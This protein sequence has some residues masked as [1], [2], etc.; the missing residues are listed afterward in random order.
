MATGGRYRVR[1]M[2]RHAF[3]NVR[4]GAALALAGALLSGC[5]LDPEVPS[6]EIA[7]PSHFLRA[8][9]NGR[10]PGDFSMFRSRTLTGL[11]E[12]AR[13]GNLDIGAA[14]ARIEQADAQVRISTQA[15]IPSL[16]ISGTSAKQM[17]SQNGRQSI[18]TPFNAQFSASYVLDFWGQNRAARY[19]AEAG[20]FQSRFD[21]ATVAIA[22]DASVANAYFQAAAARKR[23]TVSKAD[24]GAAQKDLEAIKARNKAG[25]ASGLDVA[26]QETLVATQAVTIPPLEQAYEQN[27]HAL[28]VLLGQP[29]QGFKLRVEDLYAIHIPVIRSGLPSDLLQRR[30]DIASAE[31]ALSA[32]RFNVQ[33]ARAAMFPTIQLTG[34]G[35]Y[36]SQALRSLFEPQNAFYNMAAG[37]TQPILNEYQLQAQ[38]DLDRGKYKEL[39]ETYRKS[40]VAAFQNVEDQL[41]ATKKLAE[42]ERLQQDAVKSARRAYEISSAQ[43]RSGIID[44][45]AL[46]QIQ[47]NLFNAENALAQ[48]R[49]ARLQAVVA[50]YQALGGGWERPEG[51][52]I[53]RLPRN[54]DCCGASSEANVQ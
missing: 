46:I 17:T 52:D 15:L 38:V 49:L 51:A 10:L 13:S 23:I 45:T 26:Q 28:A 42:Q 24:L 44:I 14:I 43:L 37:I 6:P 4:N 35:G 36:T 7:V 50:L 12:H 30:P 34:S 41:T 9:G 53:A 21:T 2:L 47:Q 27:L 33:S 5:L 18:S 31:A 11:V 8:T 1:G 40:I 29:P 39:M 3:T 48:V 19:A 25:T 16:D 54:D 22:T 32:A 20:A